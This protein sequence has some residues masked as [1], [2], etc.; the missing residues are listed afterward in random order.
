MRRSARAPRARLWRTSLAPL[1]VGEDAPS[2]ERHRERMYG[3]MRLRGHGSGYQLEA[4]SAIDIA[5]RDLGGE[6]LTVDGVAV[7][8]HTAAL[9]VVRQRYHR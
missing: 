4:M 3:S 2:I 7:R 8:D 5:P 1:L 9:H 6:L